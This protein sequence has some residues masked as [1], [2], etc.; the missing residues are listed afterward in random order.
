MTD[1]APVGR[2]G[3]YMRAVAKRLKEYEPMDAEQAFKV[4][5]PGYSIDVPYAQATLM[6][7]AARG[8]ATETKYGF[9]RGPKWR[10]AAKY[11]KWAE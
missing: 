9:V 6:R 2:L 5:S 11:Y 4:M 1:Y 3:V 7:L 10:A 8:I